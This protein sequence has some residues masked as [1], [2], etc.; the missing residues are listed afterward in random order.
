[1]ILGYISIIF[2]LIYLIIGYTLFTNKKITIYK[3]TISNIF[4]IGIYTTLLL[5]YIYEIFKYELIGKYLMGYIG[6]MLNVYFIHHLGVWGGGLVLVLLL[7][8]LITGLFD[9]T[10][11]NFFRNIYE[12]IKKM[13]SSIYRFI[14]II[15]NKL[16]RKKDI[17]DA[18]QNIES[19]SI[20][21]DYSQTDDL[22]ESDAKEENVTEDSYSIN[23]DSDSMKKEIN[24]IEKT[25][26]VNEVQIEEEEIVIEGNLDDKQNKE[27]KYFKYKF[28]IL[29]YLS[30]PI[31]IVE[32]NDAKIELNPVSAALKIRT[33]ST[34]LVTIMTPDI[35]RAKPLATRGAP[36]KSPKNLD[37]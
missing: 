34:P 15:K 27:S 24:T 30:N 23:I 17:E 31:E 20:E 4:S 32:H 8:I 9:I 25:N 5:G 37:P 12:L 1:M 2:P 18:D 14:L 28:P 35:D 22:K 21:K 36:I 19:I 10:I 7:V 3:Q 29:D 11:Y 33:V 26:D 13:F 6:H 16:R